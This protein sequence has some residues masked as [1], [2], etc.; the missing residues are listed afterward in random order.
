MK[1]RV[2]VAIP[3]G[4]RVIKVK[5]VKS[6]Q[7]AEGHWC[8]GETEVDSLLIRISKTMCRNE[9]DVM[10]TLFH[11]LGH[12]TFQLTGHGQTLS[13]GQ[14]E[15]IVYALQYTLARLFVFNPAAGIKYRSI[16]FGWDEE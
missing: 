11:E 16:D 3:V 10:D 6:L 8:Y 5:Y 14:E 2:P 7:D 15:A 4:D 13:E 9:Q 12:V 1:V